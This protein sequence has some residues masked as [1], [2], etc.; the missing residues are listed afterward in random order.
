MNTQDVKTHL[1]IIGG[2]GDL[3]IRKLYPALFSL[4]Q[5]GELNNVV[6][7]TGLARSPKPKEETLSAIRSRVEESGRFNEADWDRFAARIDLVAG[8]AT[9]AESLKPFAQ[10]VDLESTQLTVYFAIPPSIFESVCHALNDAGLVVPA[11]RVVIE[12]PLGTNKE[13]F[14]EIQDSLSKIFDESQVYRIDHYSRI[15]SPCDLPMLSL[16]RFGM[17]ILS[18]MYRL[19]LLKR[20]VSK[21]DMSFTKK[22]ALCVT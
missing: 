19:P 9:N 1:L 15:S 17:E 18:I 20:W 4:E 8:D 12:K 11:T 13:S 3:A 22:Q 10:G 21:T 2:D 5:A 7:I 16:V 14:M 6:A